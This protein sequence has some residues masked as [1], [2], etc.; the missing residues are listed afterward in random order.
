M[1][2]FRFVLKARNVFL[3]KHRIQSILISDVHMC[4]FTNQVFEKLISN[5]DKLYHTRKLLKFLVDIQRFDHTKYN[6]ISKDMDWLL[7][8]IEITTELFSSQAVKQFCD[9]VNASALSQKRKKEIIRL[10]NKTSMINLKKTL[11]KAYKLQ[12]F[13]DLTLVKACLQ[14]KPEIRQLIRK[15]VL[16]KIFELFTIVFI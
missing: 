11:N 2:L 10:W 9:S 13:A 1:K 14:L 12:E 7:R 15:K 3:R 4:R 8:S 16:F 6:K 5:L